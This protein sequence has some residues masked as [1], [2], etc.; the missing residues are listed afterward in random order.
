MKVEKLKRKVSQM[1][2]SE[3][4]TNAIDEKLEYRNLKERAKK[5][6]DKFFNVII[7]GVILIMITC[8]VINEIEI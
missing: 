4:N 5:S 6:A 7:I 1:R 3:S 2:E 8:Y